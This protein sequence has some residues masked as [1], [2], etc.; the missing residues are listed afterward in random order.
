[1]FRTFIYLFIPGLFLLACS[2]ENNNTEQSNIIKVPAQIP[3]EDLFD[4]DTLRGMYEGEFGKS[5]IRIV[6][7]YVSGTNAIG[8]NIHKGLQRNLNGKVQR[9]GDTVI[10]TLNEP[11]DHEYDGVFELTF[12]GIDTEPKG[13]WEHNEGWISSKKFSL[14]KH[15]KK[16]VE[17]DDE[18]NS[19][20]F[21]DYFDITFDS[22]GTYRF[23]DDGLVR[24]EYY[25]KTDE[26]SRVE[27]LIE[28]RGSWFLNDSTLRIDWQ[29]NYRFKNATS[30]FTLTRSE[31]GGPMLRG[32]GLELHP[33]YW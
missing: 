8:Y 12:I 32:E 11:G 17:N 29:E 10:V 22:L 14:K 26:E 33:M 20:N 18:I 6:L 3:E 19:S 31:W 25:P 7:N 9:N 4:Y 23:E 15:I 28:V 2:S 5:P 21:D 27:Q 30:I 16:P 24:Y 13:K 1:M